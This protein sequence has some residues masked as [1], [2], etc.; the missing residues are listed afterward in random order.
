MKRLKM[1]NRRNVL[2]IIG[3]FLLCC[4]LFAVKM[5][6]NMLNVKTEWDSIFVDRKQDF[7]SYQFSGKIINR[8]ITEKANLPYSLTIVLDTNAVIPQWGESFYY[9][10]FEFDSGNNTLTF[11]VSKYIYSSVNLNDVIKKKRESDSLYINDKA[12]R[13]LSIKPLEW[14]PK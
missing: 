2:I 13:L 10:Y 11:L 8:N 12:Y 6:K 3:C 1:K 14:I 7:K 9:Q 4:I 5:S